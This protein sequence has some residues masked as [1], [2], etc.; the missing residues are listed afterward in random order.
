MTYR[1][2]IRRRAADDL[3][4]AR[5]WYD[6]QSDGLGAKFF[7]R[8]EQTLDRIAESPQRFPLVTADV[9]KAS[10]LGFPYKVFF[11][12]RGNT[13]RVIAVFHH[14]RDPEMVA[15]RLNQ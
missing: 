10:V 15:F 9:R 4:G 12:I 6:E 2:S 5:N 14:S 11:R 1:L 13:I 8:V 3:V 7:I